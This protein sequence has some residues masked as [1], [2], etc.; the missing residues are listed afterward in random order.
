MDQA[1]SKIDRAKKHVADLNELLAKAP[2]FLYTLE[3]NLNTRKRS[4][5]VKKNEA[6]LLEAALITGDAVQNMRSSLDHTYWEIVCPFAA[7][8]K[9]TRGVQFPFSETEARLDAAVKNRLADRVSP[10]FFQAVIDLKPY[11]DDGGNSVLYLIHELGILD[12]HKLLIP[13]ADYKT[14]TGATLR[15]QVPDFPTQIDRIGFSHGYRDVEWGIGDAD[16]RFYTK[17]VTLA[18]GILEEELDVAVDIIL[19][20]SL[21]GP[22]K[23]LVPTLYQLVQAAEVAIQAMRDA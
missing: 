2:P 20:M 21:G 12:R 3:T 5:G 1:D 6:T 13:T 23:A 14:L 19:P 17:P 22:R 11:G 4:T 9:E 7:T 16:A 15:Q 10:A 8:P 18:R